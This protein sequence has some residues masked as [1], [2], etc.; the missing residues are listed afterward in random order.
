MNICCYLLFRLLLRKLFYSERL[1]SNE[2]WKNNFSIGNTVFGKT[3]LVQVGSDTDMTMVFQPYSLQWLITINWSLLRAS[4]CSAVA[5]GLHNM[6][7]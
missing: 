1:H 4:T 2:K 7:S 6:L 5:D 3:P